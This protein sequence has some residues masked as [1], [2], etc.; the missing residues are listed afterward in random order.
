AAWPGAVNRV[1]ELGGAADGSVDT[2]SA[3]LPP[4]RDVPGNRRLKKACTCCVGANVG[5]A[6]ACAGLQSRWSGSQQPV[7]GGL[8]PRR[9][10]KPAPQMCAYCIVLK[11]GFWIQDV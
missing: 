5:R 10:L 9:R 1:L 8:K 4:G 2:G 3:T 6:S 11:G 7:A